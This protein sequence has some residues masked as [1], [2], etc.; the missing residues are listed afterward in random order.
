VSTAQHATAH[1]AEIRSPLSVVLAISVAA[2]ICLLPMI[3][4]VRAVLRV[5]VVDVTIAM[6]VFAVL[7]IAGAFITPRYPRGTRV[8]LFFDSVETLLIQGAVLS[9]VYASGRGDSFFWILWLVHAMLAGTSGTRIVFHT[10]AFVA[11]PALTA[12]AFLVDG[13]VG[14]A[15]LSIA[16][17]ALG[18]YVHWIAA[19]VARRLA[20]ADAERARLAAELAETRVRQE[21]QRIARDIHDGLGADLAALDWRLRSL[22]GAPDLREEVDELVARLGHGTSEL[23]AI[24][25]ALRTPSRT[26]SE[27]VAYLRQRAAELCGDSLALELR[28]D[29][30]PSQ[31]RPGELSIGFLRAVLELVHNAVRHARATALTIHV[32]STNDALSATIGDDGAGLPPDVLEREEGGLANLRA[33]LARVGGSLSIESASRGTRIA[34]RFP[35]YS[36]IKVA[37]AATS[38]APTISE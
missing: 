19:S 7:M 20:A 29:G 13:E 26:W 6:A 9:L 15:A 2:A 22:R 24:V 10:V 34:I 14:A 25:W 35:L 27:L 38:A 12:L 1:D 31:S 17:G 21:R 30:D 3:P 11:M 18:G 8:F 23:R 4:V 36:D 16:I 32:S 33:R 5:D 28:D 37:P